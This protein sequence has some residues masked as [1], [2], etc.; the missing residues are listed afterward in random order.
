M[1]HLPTCRLGGN[2]I[3]AKSRKTNTFKYFEFSVKFKVNYQGD[4][5]MY[6]AFSLFFLIKARGDFL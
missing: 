4:S 1:M 6:D 2:K 3:N 5:T